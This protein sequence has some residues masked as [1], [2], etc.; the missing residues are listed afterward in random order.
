MRSLVA[1]IVGSLLSVVGCG[2]APGAAAPA[3][4]AVASSPSP[5]PAGRK[6]RVQVSGAGFE[7]D[8]ERIGSDLAALKAAL[9]QPG[10]AA[11]DIRAEPTA[12][13]AFIVDALT[14]E[15]GPHV[16]RRFLSW[17]E[18]ELEIS[19][20]RSASFELDQIPASIF[21][22]HNGRVSQLWSVSAGPAIANFG[23][24]EPGEKK[25]EPAV[26]SRVTEACAGKG[27]SLVV[28]LHEQRLATE[29]RAWQRLVAAL[30]P[31]LEL[32]VQKPPPPPKSEKNPEYARLPAALVQAVVRFGY[33]R[34][35][36][37]YEAGLAK[38]ANLEGKVSVR[39]VI[40]RDGM[41]KSSR[42]E[43]SDIP[44]TAVR[45]CVVHEFVGL[46]FPAPE[47]GIVTVVYPIMLSPG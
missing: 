14:L 23:P 18:L 24:Y 8:G 2:A 37:C 13:A 33:G 12:P 36:S 29:L 21:S 5:S 38:N 11:A 25:A 35:R 26:L 44:D 15:S 6:L 46:K 39:F 32:R 10:V 47:T 42:D 1:G 43:G 17:Q 40:E 20:H 45:D 41:V 9:G 28:E 22:W 7:V 27:C 19:D 4:G 30:G 16:T 3:A 34:F 31:R